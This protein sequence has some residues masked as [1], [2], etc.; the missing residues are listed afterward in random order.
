M[1]GVCVCSIEDELVLE[2]KEQHRL[3]CKDI[4]LVAQSV[5]NPQE[6][7]I[8]TQKILHCVLTATPHVELGRGVRAGFGLGGEADGGLR[9]A[10]G[11]VRL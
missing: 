10:V 1:R 6:I 8:P 9:L 2:N 4:S 5:N 7:Y 11:P 3:C